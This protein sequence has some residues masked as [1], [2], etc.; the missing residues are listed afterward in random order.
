MAGWGGTS[1]IT[2]DDVDRITA[3]LRVAGHVE[4]RRALETLHTLAER[5][6][7]RRS[8]G[9]LLRAAT[10]EF[11]WVP[12]VPEDPAEHLVDLLRHDC[13]LVGL[14]E[15]ERT[16]ALTTAGG[17]RAVL[18]LLAMRGDEPS[19]D[20]LAHLLDTSARDGLLPPACDGLLDPLLSNP[21]AGRLAGS[22]VAAMELQ[23][24]AP[25]CA[26]LL[27]QIVRRGM[28]TAEE[29]AE[30]TRDLRERAL[31]I[32]DES[33]R[34]APPSLRG[35]AGRSDAGAGDPLRLDRRRLHALAEVLAEL[36]TEIA[37]STLRRLLASVD[38]ATSAAAA[39][40]LV[41]RGETVADERLV[42]L[43]RDPRSRWILLRGL[44]RL[45]RQFLL[46]GHCWEAK[47]VAEA[48]MVNWLASA[49]QLRRVPDEIEHRGVA[50]APAGWGTGLLHLFAFRVH[51]PHFAAE[52]DW[53]FG[54][55]GPWEPSSELY[56]Q[57][58]SDF[59]AHSLYE[60]FDS[61]GR[62]EHLVA[63]RDSLE[64]ERRS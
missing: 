55:V 58:G 33:D 6:V 19:V 48:E 59:A 17:R 47:A 23:G 5:T 64:A 15:L 7:D 14:V 42:L 32:V 38:P 37:G 61:A 8:A 51:P 52:R 34:I 62:L 63:L 46:P 56:P 30:V 29:C 16:Y 13:S 43:T 31:G 39:V 49:N 10:V 44:S 24:W 35:T 4:R 22:L 50:A 20:A 12:G 45:G 40:S 2:T 18:G 28:L 26:R 21:C 9:A 25:Y 60:S 3:E 54:A 41:A 57:A 11:P 36:S 53:M 1:H 27:V